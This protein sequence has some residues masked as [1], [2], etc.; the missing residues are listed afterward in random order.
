MSIGLQ[1]KS[2]MREVDNEIEPVQQLAANTIEV[3]ESATPNDFN[4][5]LVK[6]SAKWSMRVKESGAKTD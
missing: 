5:F 3:A 4:A 6:E 1:K 2:R